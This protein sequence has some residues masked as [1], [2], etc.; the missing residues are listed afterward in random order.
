MVSSTAL[1]MGTVTSQLP[2][3]HGTGSPG[4]GVHV[5]SAATAVPASVRTACGDRFATAGTGEERDRS[6]AMGLLGRC[7]GQRAFEMDVP[8]FRSPY[9]GQMVVITSPRR[10]AEAKTF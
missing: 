2:F 8:E 6:E 7:E 3:T 10:L 4:C 9:P 1:V 5:P